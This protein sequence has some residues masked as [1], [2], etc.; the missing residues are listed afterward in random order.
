MPLAP[1]TPWLHRKYLASF[2][3]KFRMPPPPRPQVFAWKRF[4]RSPT[5]SRGSF[6]GS[7]VHVTILLTTAWRVKTIFYST[8]NSI[9]P[10]FSCYL[11]RLSRDWG[12]RRR[13]LWRSPQ[14]S[15]E[16]YHLAPV[17]QT[18]HRI[19]RYAVNEPHRKTSCVIRWIVISNHYP[20]DY[21]CFLTHSGQRYP[22]FKNRDLDAC[23]CHFWH[24][25]WI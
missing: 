5:Q 21:L 8:V 15:P 12:G 13:L 23:N 3:R 16:L 25:F 1:T 4:Q 20:A 22:P 17:V 11:E 18:I 19:N 24:C 6:L 10:V 14:L 7:S 2:A 9:A